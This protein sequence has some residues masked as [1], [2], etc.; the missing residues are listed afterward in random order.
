MIFFRFRPRNC[1][2]PALLF[3]VWIFFHRRAAWL[4]KRLYIYGF[5]GVENR[6]HYV[7]VHGA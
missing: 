7:G 3:S 4:E 6:F 2:F 1:F 5:S